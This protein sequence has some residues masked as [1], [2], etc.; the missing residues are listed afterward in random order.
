MNLQTFDKLFPSA[1]TPGMIQ[2]FIHKGEWAVHEVLPILF[3]K[4]G[5]FNVAIATFSISED[6]LR[7][8]FFMADDCKIQD[9]TILLDQTVKRH[10]LD[11]LLFA[12]SITRNIRIESNHSKILLVWNKNYQFGIVGSANLNLNAR[13]EAGFYFSGGE[14]FDFFK[15]QFFEIYGNAIDIDT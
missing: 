6:S 1:L 12:E 9:L 7:S 4:I 11:M 3:E 10:K 8:L 14:H 2:P 13:F 15:Q 5:C